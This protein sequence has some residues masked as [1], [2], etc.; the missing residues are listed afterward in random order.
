VIGGGGNGM[1]KIF[2]ASACIGLA[3]VLG[4]GSETAG[5]RRAVTGTVSYGGQPVEEGQIVFEPQAAG[6]PLATGQI[7]GGEYEIDAKYGPAT[8]PY[9]VRIEGF[10]K[11]KLANM[12]PHPYAGDSPDA[13]TVAEQYLPATYNTRS[14]LQVEIKD[15]D[16]GVHNF[17]LQAKSN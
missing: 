14:T 6:A 3:I 5:G 17:D 2:R 9:R 10:R 1:Q 12:P 13:S 15:E 8:G 7:K 16:E 11:K 4:C